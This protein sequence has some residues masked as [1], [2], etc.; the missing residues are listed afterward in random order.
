MELRDSHI[1]ERQPEGHY[2]EPL[3]VD[4]ALMKRLAQFLPKYSTILDPC[5][6]FGRIVRA[7]RERGFI[8]DGGDIIRR[9]ETSPDGDMP[10]GGTFHKVDYLQAEGH[11]YDAIVMNPPYGHTIDFVKKA[12][13]EARILVAAIVPATWING[14]KTARWLAQTPWAYYWPISPRPSMP[15]GEYLTAGQV[16][17]GGRKDFAV[18]V[19]CPCRSP[20]LLPQVE[21]LF[22]R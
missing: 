3:D 8:A 16:A 2:C 9:W 11:E 17:G 13:G 18:L 6:G 19:W 20:D 14:A 21:H 22:W 7:A 4:R 1:F 5:C 15:P 12:L 10:I